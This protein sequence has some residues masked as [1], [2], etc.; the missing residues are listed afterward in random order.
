MMTKQEE[1]EELESYK[2]FMGAMQAEGEELGLTYK[3][4]VD[5]HENHFAGQVEYANARLEKLRSEEK[6]I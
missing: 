4:P 6:E 3:C 2:E 1:I 5:P